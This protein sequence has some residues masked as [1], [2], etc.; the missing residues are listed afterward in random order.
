MSRRK[1]IIDTNQLRFDFDKKI[2][3]Y[4]D[5]KEEIL[6]SSESPPVK[7]FESYEEACI[8]LAASVKRAIRQRGLSREQM[9]DAVN[10]YFG[11]PKGEAPKGK[12]LS[13]HMFNH[14]L[15][16]PARYP[17]PAYLIFAIQ[18][19]TNSLEPT[20]TLAETE[21]AKVIS[22]DEVRQMALGKLDDTIIEMQRLKRELRGGK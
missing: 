14:Y 21:D 15:S 19:I 9:V 5:L 13:I 6:V 16:K 18:R 4:R 1:K 12:N 8:E 3:E 7:N 20:K 11:W 22:G 2:D 17:M 10:D